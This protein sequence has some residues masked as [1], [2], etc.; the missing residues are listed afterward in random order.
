MRTTVSLLSRGRG[1]SMALWHC[2]APQILMMHGYMA[3]GVFKY[4]R[5]HCEHSL[6]VWW[7]SASVFQP[8]HM[9]MPS[10][11]LRINYMVDHG[12]ASYQDLAR[13]WATPTQRALRLFQHAAADENATARP[14]ARPPARA[15]ARTA[16]LKG[17]TRQDPAARATCCQREPRCCR[18]RSWTLAT[19]SV[20][21]PPWRGMRR[22]SHRHACADTATAAAA[23][24]AAADTGTAAAA[25]AAAG[26]R[27][28]GG[29]HADER[30]REGQSLG[31]ARSG[32]CAAS[33]RLRAVHG[34]DIAAPLSRQMHAYA[35]ALHAARGLPCCPRP[36][37]SRLF[38][39]D[40]FPRGWHWV[41]APPFASGVHDRPWCAF[42]HSNVCPRLRPRVGGR[43]CRGAARARTAASACSRTCRPCRASRAP[44]A[45]SSARDL[46]ND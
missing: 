43:R 44:R 2:A 45:A 37:S 42:K 23:A 16:P 35:F 4:A 5:T 36:E 12:G 39:S 25:A 31:M 38:S 13:R 10:G 33:C 3:H 19:S 9:A 28:R 17:R 32:P 15:R 22:A 18:V 41:S 21:V 30:A 8:D 34:N 40:C 11:L 46:Q 27:E 6:P 14:P 24:A 29:W 26:R 20:T 1:R 7:L